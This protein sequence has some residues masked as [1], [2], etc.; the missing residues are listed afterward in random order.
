[1]KCGKCQVDM[2]KT[3]VDDSTTQWTC[4]KCGKIIEEVIYDNL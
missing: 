2:V 1:M 3:V 4:P